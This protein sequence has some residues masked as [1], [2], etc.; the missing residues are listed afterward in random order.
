MKS[1]EGLFP[2]VTDDASRTAYF[3]HDASLMGQ[4]GSVFVV[5]AQTHRRSQHRRR[6]GGLPLARERVARG[7]V[8]ASALM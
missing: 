3:L 8:T 6:A 5:V 7:L 1:E 2:G 4:H